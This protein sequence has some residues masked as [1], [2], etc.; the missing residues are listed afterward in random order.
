[1]LSPP[2]NPALNIQKRD[3]PAKRRERELTRGGGC[4]WPRGFSYANWHSSFSYGRDLSVLK[5]RR[6]RAR[7]ER[8]RE[9]YGRSVEKDG[10]LD[11]A[12]IR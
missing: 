11:D 4:C 12:G 10:K 9:R 6:R 8:E 3:R 7:R 5:V 2:R 1:M